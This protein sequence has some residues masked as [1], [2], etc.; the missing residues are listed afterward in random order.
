MS[1]PCPAPAWPN[2][3][4]GP[5]AF[6]GQ[7]IKILV[8][9]FAITMGSFFAKI[10]R[11]PTHAR[12]YFH[13]K[14]IFCI[15]LAHRI[16]PSLLAH[17]APLSFSSLCACLCRSAFGS[18]EKPSREGE[19]RSSIPSLEGHLVHVLELLPPRLTQRGGPGRG[20]RSIR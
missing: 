15:S 2:Q 17:H 18:N 13:F 9:S 10:H 20:R 6:T 11:N 3:P 7:K 14:H 16:L 1:Q 12:F 19:C 4:A 8:I 5:Q